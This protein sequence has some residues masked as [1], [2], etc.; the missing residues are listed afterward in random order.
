LVTKGNT[1]KV[2]DS[3]F[4]VD[5]RLNNFGCDRKTQ[6]FASTD[7]N[8]NFCLEVL[9]S[10]RFEV[11][12][13]SLSVVS[14]DF[15]RLGVDGKL[16]VIAD[17]MEDSSSLHLI[18]NMDCMA[19]CLEADVNVSKG[20]DLFNKYTLRRRDIALAFDFFVSTVLDLHDEGFI[21]VSGSSRVKVDL[22][23]FVLSSRDNTAERPRCEYTTWVKPVEFSRSVTFVGDHKGLLDRH[24]HSIVAKVELQG[25]LGEGKADGIS[26]S[27]HQEGERPVIDQ[28]SD[29]NIEILRLGRTEDNIES[30]FLTRRDALGSRARLAKLRVLVEKH[31]YVD[32]LSQIVANVEALSGGALNESGSKRDL[33]RTSGDFLELLTSEL[34]GAVFDFLLSSR[35]RLVLLLN[36]SVLDGFLLSADTGQAGGR[37]LVFAYWLLY[38]EV[39]DVLY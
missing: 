11:H 25:L 32:R 33:L 37:G 23:L 18:L 2:D 7:V 30:S 9:L 22:N 29:R 3:L 24:I 21:I 14:L 35:L 5:V 34:D 36:N 38:V 15:T 26:R 4:D 17:D 16:F 13:E 39:V 20:Q 8:D 1:T 31:A 28:V 12:S 6:L 27:S 10:I 19:L